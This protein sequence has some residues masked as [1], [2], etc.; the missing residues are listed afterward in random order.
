[1]FIVRRL[2]L[3]RSKWMHFLRFTR[4]EDVVRYGKELDT[5]QG[6]D[7]VSLAPRL[8]IGALPDNVLLDIF[9]ECIPGLMHPPRQTRA[10]YQLVHVC[11]RWRYV[12]LASPLRLNLRLLCTENTP[13]R[14]TLDIWPP[15]PIEIWSVGAK[16][17][18]D[19]ITA[20]LEH[21]DR[22]CGIW[23]METHPPLEHL[24]TVMQE[25]FPALEF[26]YLELETYA[27]PPP[28]LPNTFLGGTA[29]R[30]RSLCLD[31]IPFPTLPKLLLSC[32]DLSRLSLLQTP[33]SGYISPQ[34]MVRS[35]S[36]LTRL[37]FLS[38][39][40]ES[41]A[42][43]PD[44]W[45]RHP[46]PLTRAVLAALTH[47]RFYGVSEYLEDLVA[48][49]NAPLLD[50]VKVTLFNQLVFDTRQLPQFIYHAS[51]FIFYNQAE[52]VFSRDYIQISL[53]SQ[54]ITSSSLILEIRCGGIDW[55]VS[56]MAQI[57][58]HFSFLLSGIERLYI[59]CF[60]LFGSSLQVDMDTTQWIELFH[61]FTAVQTLSVSRELR[62][63]IVLALQG[64]SEELV[65]EVLPALADLYLEGNQTFIA[66]LHRFGHPIT[67][68]RGRAHST[69]TQLISEST[70]YEDTS[71]VPMERT[72]SFV[73]TSSISGD[74][75]D[76]EAPIAA[77]GA[78]DAH[79]HPAVHT[80]AALLSGGPDQFP[81]S[82]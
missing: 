60:G 58:R 62:S 42:S 6:Q 4:Q 53:R 81:E 11:R 23:F 61:P 3:L 68:H 45:T 38:I 37:T 9:E 52:I 46:P 64:L 63:S 74:A 43:C 8:T 67:I 40:F 20:A 80:S 57:C 72:G 59:L 2:E 75:E 13:V 14:K 56:S 44:R 51:I 26:F 70:V 69:S 36:A 1:M 73:F 55:Q 30:L 24:V 25:P 47:F 54:R 34:A 31:R 79:Y 5:A 50:A 12:V 18:R 82:D 39:G 33:H 16:S 66:A 10:W 17:P 77:A 27:A 49:I 7:H 35:I 48:G 21:P 32:N 76:T 19:N 78:V 41:P 71:T 28:P 29:P 15:L 22:I 65:T